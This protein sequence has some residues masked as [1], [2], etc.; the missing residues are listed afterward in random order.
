MQIPFNVFDQRFK[1]Y[2]KELKKR[3]IEIH[4]RS[5][6]LQGL[7]FLEPEKMGTHFSDY[8]S[9]F[10]EFHTKINQSGYSIV[11]VCLNYVNIQPEVDKI[12]IGICKEEE[13]KTNLKALRTV[14]LKDKSF[15]NSFEQFQ[16]SNEKIILPFNWN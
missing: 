3:N 12:I 15:Y 1:P 9:H 6:F 11:E 14:T 5:V 4:I 7:V 2:F 16:I 10:R 13:L 8:I